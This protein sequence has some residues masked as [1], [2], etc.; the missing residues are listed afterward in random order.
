ML[1]IQSGQVKGQLNIKTR[2]WEKKQNLEL[3]EKNGTSKEIHTCTKRLVQYSIPM[4]SLGIAGA[5]VDIM[6]PPSMILFYYISSTLIVF[7]ICN[8]SDVNWMNDD[9]GWLGLRRK[10]CYT[11]GTIWLDQVY[12]VDEKKYIGWIGCS[13]KRRVTGWR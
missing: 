7:L 1:L 11:P 10:K 8:V 13:W 9:R 12:M 4:S 3:V 2:N 5:P 6:I